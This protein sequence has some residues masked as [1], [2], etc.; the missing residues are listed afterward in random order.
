VAAGIAVS[1]VGDSVV[2]REN[3]F[4]VATYFAEVAFSLAD[5]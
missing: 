1:T 3:Y 5:L 4:V 2:E